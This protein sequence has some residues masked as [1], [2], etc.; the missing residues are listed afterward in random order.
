RRAERD[1]PEREREAVDERAHRVLADPE[2]DVPSLEM[3]LAERRRALDIRLGGGVEIGRAPHQRRHQRGRALLEDPRL[4]ARPRVL[5]RR[6]LAELLEQVLRDLSLADLLVERE[7][8][9]AALL[10]GADRLLPGLVRLLA[11]LRALGEQGAH[12]V[13]H[14]E[15]RLLG[16]A[17][18]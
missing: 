3:A 1:E 12:L 13:R 11:L 8:L 6:R 9:A 5:G 18:G 17:I 4:R 10:E 2:M 14:E 15:G 16:P 7:R